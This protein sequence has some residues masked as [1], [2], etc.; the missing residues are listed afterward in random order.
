M[1]QLLAET[2]MARY[3]SG[4]S[5]QATVLR[6]EVERTRVSERATDL[7]AERA[8][9][10]ATLNRLLN[11][12]PATP[13]GQVVTLPELPPLPGALA[14]LPDV[15]AGVAPDVSVRKADAEASARRVETAR[16]ELRPNLTVGG[17][18]FWQGGVNRVVS[19]T[20]GV[21]WPWRKDRKQQALIAAAEREKEAAQ[22]ELEDA[23]SA[24][25]SEAA[26]LVIAVEQAEAQ[27]DR[28]RSGLL[29]QSSAALDAARASYLG[30][31]GDF[32]SV[33]DEFRRWTDVRVELARREAGRFSARGALDVLVNPAEHG[34][35]G[36][37]VTR[38]PTSSKEPRS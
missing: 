19:V 21:E 37:A 31:R 32:A 30:G 22:L 24:M 16:A 33:L 27:I 38:E 34:T 20:L 3:S 10:V 9:V 13:L 25:R 14:G 35:W 36:H 6:A 28:Y 11:Q 1:A 7:G 29:P 15:A 5:D 26:R 18:F 2:A 8:T 4:N 17:S 12:P 23:A